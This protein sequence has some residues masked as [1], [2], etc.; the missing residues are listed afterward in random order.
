ME[1][2]FIG[3]VRNGQ[4][5]MR[6]L[7]ISLE[8]IPFIGSILKAFNMQEVKVKDPVILG[9]LSKHSYLLFLNDLIQDPFH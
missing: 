5:Q 9:K 7:L 4:Q 1:G 2:F 3:P 6:P 8:K